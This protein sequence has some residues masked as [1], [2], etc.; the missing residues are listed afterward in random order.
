MELKVSLMNVRFVLLSRTESR[1][2]IHLKNSKVTPRRS[3][4]SNVYASPLQIGIDSVVV[5]LLHDGHLSILCS[6]HT[7]LAHQKHDLQIKKK[8]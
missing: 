4:K 7:Q 3:S 6:L 8:G 5:L 1:A 2:F